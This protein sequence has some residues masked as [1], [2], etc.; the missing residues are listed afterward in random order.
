MRNM[1][2]LSTVVILAGAPAAMAEDN[3]A[4]LEASYQGTVTGDAEKD[5]VAYDLRQASD[6]WVR[7]SPECFTGAA[8]G[9]FATSA[10]P[11]AA[12]QQAAK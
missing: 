11:S 7:F 12:I 1:I 6:L 4:L 3:E 8:A 10:V 2:I 9:D 5:T